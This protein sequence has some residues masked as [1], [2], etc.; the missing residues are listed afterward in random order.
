MEIVKNE[1]TRIVE[2]WLTKADQR[3]TD[4]MNL[5]E[6]LFKKWNAEKYLPVIYRSGSDDLYGNTL[7]LLKHNRAVFIRRE[8]ELEK[9]AI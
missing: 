5:L 7:A 8:V 9:K 3:D 2:I 1:E 6:P 4:C